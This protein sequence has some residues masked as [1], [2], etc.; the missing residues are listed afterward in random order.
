MENFDLMETTFFS[1]TSEMGQILQKSISLYK[2]SLVQTATNH[3]WCFE[4]FSLELTENFSF[5][6][7]Y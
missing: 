7:N 4:A 1:P 2:M 6:L 5:V 3:F